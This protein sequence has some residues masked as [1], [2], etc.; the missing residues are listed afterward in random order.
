[1]LR[2]SDIRESRIEVAPIEPALVE[3]LKVEKELF[4][5]RPI[6]KGVIVVD[7]SSKRYDGLKC[8]DFALENQLDAGVNMSEV[9]FSESK[10]QI[11]ERI[12][13]SLNQ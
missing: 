5:G 3:Y 12:Q 9:K 11:V 13:K 4:E 8:S 10:L 7:D 1:M 2:Y 6:S